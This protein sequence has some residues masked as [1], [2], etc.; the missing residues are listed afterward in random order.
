MMNRKTSCIQKDPQKETIISNHR[1]LM[2]LPMIWKIRTKEEIHCSLKCRGLFPEAQKG[3]KW[4]DDILYINQYILKAG[5]CGYDMDWLQKT[6]TI[7]PHKLVW[8]CQNVWK[9]IKYTTKSENSSWKELSAGGQ[10]LAAVK[11]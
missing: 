8:Y 4:T 2:C 1:P 3:T 11:I 7:W 9:C 6:S 5:K 10:T